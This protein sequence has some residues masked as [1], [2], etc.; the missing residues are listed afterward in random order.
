LAQIGTVLPVLG[1]KPAKD[2]SFRETP[3]FWTFVAEKGD[4]QEKIGYE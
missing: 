2:H 3:K 1:G 4:K